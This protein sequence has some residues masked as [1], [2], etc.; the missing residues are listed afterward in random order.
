MS[1]PN[2]LQ[3]GTAELARELFAPL[4]R[5]MLKRLFGGAGIYCDALF[6]A[7]IHDGAIYLKVSPETEALFKAAGSEPFVYHNPKRDKPVQ[8]SYWTLP[9]EALDDPDCAVLWGRRALASARAAAAKPAKKR[10]PAVKK[11][12][13]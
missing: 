5:I 8:L 1:K 13:E 2:P 12:Q 3:D 10:A 7:L 9:G 6:F 11:R 4:G